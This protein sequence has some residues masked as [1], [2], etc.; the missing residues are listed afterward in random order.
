MEIIITK[1]I[2]NARFVSRKQ[3]K[4]L[5]RFAK[6]LWLMEE[7]PVVV[8]GSVIY[9]LDLAG[10]QALEGR[11]TGSGVDKLGFYLV[12]N[13]HAFN[14]N[15]DI[16]DL[17]HKR[18]PPGPAVLTEVFNPHTDQAFEALTD[19][20]HGGQ[21]IFHGALLR[22]SRADGDMVLEFALGAL[23]DRSLCIELA[24]I[25]AEDCVRED[26]GGL[27]A[28]ADSRVREVYFRK[29]EKGEYLVRIDNTYSDLVFPPGTNCF[30]PPVKPKIVKH[31]NYCTIGCRSIQVRQGNFFLET[32]KAAGI[33][34]VE[35]HK[36][37]ENRGEL[38]RQ[39]WREAF[40]QG[41][42]VENIYLDQFLWHVF[43]YNRLEALTGEEASARLNSAGSSVLYI[44]LNDVRIYDR[45]I[46]YRLENAAAFRH[47]ML[48]CYQDVYVT[49]ENCSW[50]YVKTHEE[51]LCGPYFYSV[52]M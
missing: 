49:D 3:D 15:N 38:L 23:S 18:L 43:S 41:V 22:M 34:C 14:L 40:L 12:F 39:R 9:R 42:D 1:A 46:C 13:L 32:L 51:G 27:A 52:N 25:T 19:K 28:F 29:N 17:E 26:G 10:G 24:G 44:F 11:I 8:D 6:R 35:L 20:R 33:I 45:D 48:D 47:E 2:S 21:H 16:L 31:V 50:T 5:A 30:S 7:I 37:D 4:L 36:Q